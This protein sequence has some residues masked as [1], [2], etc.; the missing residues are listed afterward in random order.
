[1]CEAPGCEACEQMRTAAVEL[2]TKRGVRSITNR[3][4]AR[5]ARLSPD[6][7]MRHYPSVDACLAAAYHQGFE[8]MVEACTPALS[9]DGNWQERLEAACAATID[10][11]ETRPQLGRFCMVE[12]WRINLPQ[13]SRERMLARERS[14]ALLA[15]QRRPDEVEDELPDLR[16]ELF[17]GATHHA[18]GQELQDPDC[19]PRTIRARFAALVGMFEPAPAST[20]A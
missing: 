3:A 9:G 4:L 11:F 16:F 7:A 14:V 15:E 5:R 13:L 1:M 6:E 2:A 10:A 20:P 18:I 8:L 19:S 17:A 12:A